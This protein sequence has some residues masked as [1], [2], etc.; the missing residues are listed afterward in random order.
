[1]LK[2]WMG[3]R[4]GMNSMYPYFVFNQNCGVEETEGGNQWRKIKQ[5]INKT[6]EMA[7]RKLREEIEETK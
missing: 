3:V 7:V 6:E 5:Q 1:M 2:R 4:R